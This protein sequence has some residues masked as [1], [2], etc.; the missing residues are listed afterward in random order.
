MVTR[1]TRN[2]LTRRTAWRWHLHLLFSSSSLLPLFP[3]V[4]KRGL[5]RPPSLLTTALRRD[6][7]DDS[8]RCYVRVALSDSLSAYRERHLDA[9]RLVSFSTTWRSSKGYPRS[10]VDREKR[11]VGAVISSLLLAIRPLIC[12]WMM[13]KFFVWYFKYNVARHCFYIAL[14]SLSYLILLMDWL[15]T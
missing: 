3:S 12:R 8:A 4:E 15:S 10:R 9:A 5:D 7:N 13:L 11:R 14:F 1:W 2:S 6:D